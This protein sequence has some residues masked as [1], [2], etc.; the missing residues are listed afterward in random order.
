[1][2]LARDTSAAPLGMAR[3]EAAMR[4][5]SG[6]IGGV[7]LCEMSHLTSSPAAAVGFGFRVSGFGFR[8]SGLLYRVQG[9][10]LRVL[11]SGFTGNIWAPRDASVLC[12]G[13]R[14]QG[15]PA[16]ASTSTS[17]ING[18]R[19]ARVIMSLAGSVGPACPA[20]ASP[21][22]CGGRGEGGWKSYIIHPWKIS[23]ESDSV[24]V[25]L[26]ISYRHCH[27]SHHVGVHLR[28]TPP[29]R[30]SSVEERCGL[31]LHLAPCRAAAVARL[32][33]LHRWAGVGAHAE[34]RS[35]QQLQPHQHPRALRF[36]VTQGLHGCLAV[37][38]GCL[39]VRV[40]WVPLCI[41]RL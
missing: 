11:G 17:T 18:P 3:R 9:S 7:G 33:C 36:E 34:D 20:S 37:L 15:S 21:T 16:H 4:C 28:Q 32:P 19:F 13:F 23:G 8:V 35:L 30:E 22:T 24:R 10:G 14:V 27:A 38:H 39:C 40:T 5:S 1:M 25:K 2:A 29:R 41:T 12:S 6:T 26:G 31:V